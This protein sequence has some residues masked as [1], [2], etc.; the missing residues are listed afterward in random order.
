MH[1]VNILV[2]RKRVMNRDGV[3]VY[4]SEQGYFVILIKDE[5][6]VAEKPV[7]LPMANGIIAFSALSL[8]MGTSPFSRN[9]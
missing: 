7:F 1:I 2:L 6:V 3:N 8:S 4:R 5:E 9:V